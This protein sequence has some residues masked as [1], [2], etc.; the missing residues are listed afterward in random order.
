MD[1]L[2]IK[3]NDK[4]SEVEYLTFTAVSKNHLQE[5]FH[6]IRSNEVILDKRELNKVHPDLQCFVQYVPLTKLL[7]VAQDIRQLLQTNQGRE[8]I[9]P[10]PYKDR[11]M[12]IRVDTFSQPV[13]DHQST[14]ELI[15]LELEDWLNS[16]VERILNVL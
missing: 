9:R 12:F 1:S 15:N 16:T 14:N 3:Y 7:N 5:V 11:F 2:F 13:H 8:Y 10:F 6:Q 4:L